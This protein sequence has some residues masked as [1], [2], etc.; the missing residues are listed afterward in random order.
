MKNYDIIIIGSGFKAMITAY[1]A[2]R[3]YKNILIIAKSGDIA[4]VMSPIKWK[5]GNFDKGYQFFDGL[6]IEQKELLNDFIGENILHDFGYGAASLTNKKL[7][8]QHA[9]PYWPYKGIKFSFEICLAYMVNFFKNKH[10]N[11]TI[12]SY[13]DLIENL[14]LRIKNILQ[15]ECKRRLGITPD[16]ISYLVQDFLPIFNYRQTIFPDF[17]A[18]FLKKNFKYFDERIASRRKSMNL[19][20]ISLYPKGKNIGAAAEKMQE[21]LT[22]HGVKIIEINGLKIMNKE[23]LTVISKD[24]S[25]SCKKIFIVTELDDALNFFEDKIT[26]EKNNYYLPQIFYYFTTDRINSKF[27][28]VHGNDKDLL[29]NRG[30]NMSLYGEKTSENKFVL[31]AEVPANPSSEVWKNADQYT[32]IVWNELKDMKLVAPNQEYSEFEIFKLNKTVSLPLISFKNTINKLNKLIMDKFKNQV[33]LPGLGTI[34]RAHFITAL[35]KHFKGY[36]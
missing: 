21:K 8:S 20:C 33:E 35:T 14:P 16:K 25:F 3:K 26:D 27:Q 9:L 23:K 18:N 31:S 19:D 28:Y 13:Q 5:G 4:G 1:F 10:K 11:E 36:E 7:Y 22:K 29:V 6:N 2:L 30:N 32:K 12:E 17:F 24:Q 34:S 15:Y